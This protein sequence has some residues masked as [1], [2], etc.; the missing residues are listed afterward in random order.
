MTKKQMKNLIEELYKID[1]S[2]KAYGPQL[3]KMITEIIKSRPDV[4][5]DEN[6]KKELYAELMASAEKLAL[7]KT[8]K[9]NLWQSFF[10]AKFSYAVAGILAI[11]IL[12]GFWGYFTDIGGA[13][14]R[15]KTGLE[16]KFT[17]TDLTDNAFGSLQG[18]AGIEETGANPIT[19]PAGRGGGGGG[20]GGYS[21][22]EADMAIKACAG[23]EGCILPPYRYP[24]YVY[25]GEEIKLEQSSVEVLRKKSKVEYAN[26]FSGLLETF[27]FGLADLSVFENARIQTINLV[28][29]KDFGYT[30]FINLDEGTI[31]MD[32]N[33]VKWPQ[34]P[35]RCP[36]ER[37]AEQYQLKENDLLGD[38]EL[39]KIA[40]R[41]IDEHGINMDAYGEPEVE[42]EWRREYE[43]AKNES[44]LYVPETISVLYPLV[45]DDKEVYEQWGGKIGARIN[46][47]L[48]HKRV[49]GIYNLSFQNYDSSRYEAETD[50]ARII[51][52]AEKGGMNTFIP[53]GTETIKTELGTP[54]QAYMAFWRYDETSRLNQMLFVPALIFP[55]LSDSTNGYYYPDYITIPLAKELLQ[56][57]QDSPYPVPLMESR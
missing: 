27:G 41:F 2:L 15:P 20:V 54:K 24:Q 17:K 43:I 30:I 50:A 40:S 3:E 14:F 53:E 4:S 31:S 42:N 21:S 22:A 57:N 34:P 6:F 48:R 26:S 7:T 47:S 32:M 25:V 8:K 49:S 51:K 35:D 16:L 38:G 10:P 13:L 29:D 45:L 55:V 33:W 12:V 46:I 23:L 19:A 44:R 9:N 28:Q 1:K 56:E 37:C 11:F 36:D 5:I 39:I 52:I 18:V